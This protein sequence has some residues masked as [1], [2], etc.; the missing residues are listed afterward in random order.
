[1]HAHSR[2]LEIR[3]ISEKQ[4]KDKV[5]YDGSDETIV[6]IGNKLMKNL[7]TNVLITRGE[8]GMSMFEKN[9]NITNIPTNAKNNTS[10]EKNI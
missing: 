1:M 6:E 5:F 8:K 2:E 10:V 9:G 7:N 4:L 3:G